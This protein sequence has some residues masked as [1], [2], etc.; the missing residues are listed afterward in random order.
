MAQTQSDC[1]A[2]TMISESKL[3]NWDNKVRTG[4]ML[5]A[6]NAF[7]F[8]MIFLKMS[9]V[10]LF[11]YFVIGFLIFSILRNKFMG[12]EESQVDSCVE[13]TIK[14][15]ATMGGSFE[16]MI[17]KASKMED[18]THTAKFAGFFYGLTF[19]AS[20]FSTPFVCI[21]VINVLFLHRPVYVMQK[22]K[23]DKAFTTVCDMYTKHSK[24]IV[25]K[26]PKYV[27][28]VKKN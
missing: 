24:M 8:S 11:S 20:I 4:V 14:T 2:C 27:E 15:L 21:S 12:D 28:A 1:G 9:L 26:I 19:I 10:G 25:D 22:D 5:G 3:F 6:L 13:D 16:E 18:F 7:F 23:I 17:N